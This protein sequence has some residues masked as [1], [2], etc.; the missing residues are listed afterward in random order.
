MK[1]LHLALYLFA[2]MAGYAQKIDSEDSIQ[3]RV[4]LIGDGGAFREGKHPVVSA[5]KNYFKPD[6]KTTIVYLG[7]NV[8]R[9]GLPDAAHVDYQTIRAVLDTQVNVARNTPAR[10]IMIPGNHDWENG[11]RYGYDAL[12]R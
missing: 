1:Y 9:H 5:I 6:K 4:L 11:G 10:V 2:C 7:D 8:Y 3:S 12:M